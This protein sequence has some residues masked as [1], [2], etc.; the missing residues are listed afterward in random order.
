MILGTQK[1]LSKININDY[2]PIIVRNLKINFVD[3]IKNLGIW[4]DSSLTWKA[5]TK[6]ITNRVYSVL[7]SLKLHKNS[8]T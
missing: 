3:E 5:Q 1:T 2:D 7:Y 6:K 4:F 8:L